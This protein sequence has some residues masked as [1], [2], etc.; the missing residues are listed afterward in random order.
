MRRTL[1]LAI[2]IAVLAT[3]C[4]SSGRPE[5]VATLAEDHIAPTFAEFARTATDLE[6]STSRLCVEPSAEHLEVA[7]NDLASA[8]FEWSRSEAMWIGPVMERRS[9]AVID[10]PAATEEIDVLIDDAEPLTVDRLRARVGADQRGLQAVEYVIASDDVDGTLATL[11]GRRCDFLTAV[12]SVIAGEARLVDDDW[13]ATGEDSARAVIAGDNTTAVDEL[14]NDIA[15]L[16]EAIADAELGSALGVMDREADVDA[17]VEGPAGLGVADLEAHAAG[18]R[19]VLIGPNGDAGLGPLLADG[20]RD[21]LDAALDDIDSSLAGI[22]GPL[23]EAVATTPADVA[24]NRAAWKQLQVLVNTEVVSHLGVTIGFS[25][26]D[27][28]TGA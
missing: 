16:L 8:R 12:T 5:A 28:D 23:R 17:I 24:T 14:V 18:I 6:A 7:R 27:G 9:W 21:R 13:A 10:W 11:A 2:A 15:F 20:L 22:E 25:D 19:T 3:G 26:A 4:S 1:V